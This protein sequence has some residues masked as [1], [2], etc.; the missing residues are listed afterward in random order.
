MIPTFPNFKKL[1]LNDR[2]AI[3]DFTKQFP[4]YNDF[5]FIDLWIYNPRT[6]TAISILD[7]NLVVNRQDYITDESFY[8]FLGTNNAK[9]TITKLLLKSKEENLAPQLKHIPEISIISSPNLQDFFSITEDQDNF[10]YI[11]SV[12]ELVSLMGSKYHNKRNLVKLFK[13][14]YSDYVIKRLDLTQ[15]EIKQE[16]KKLFYLWEKQKGRKR[17]ETEIELIAVEK[18]F[19]LAGL[20]NISGL[21]VY[22]KNKLIGFTTYHLLPGNYAGMSLQKGDN[23]YQGIYPFLNHETAKIL[24][25]LGCAYLNYEQDLGI[26]GLKKAKKLWRPVFYLK[27]YIIKERA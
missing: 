5:E 17:S 7:N 9:N 3:E 23:T 8:T 14:L 16:I 11:L 26:S 13:K 20:R 25:E 24:K 4:P 15:D 12:N 1:E 10:D 22:H 2:N 27:K 21:G 6:D 19:D 18:L